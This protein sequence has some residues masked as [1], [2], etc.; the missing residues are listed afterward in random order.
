S[1]SALLQKHHFEPWAANW[2]LPELQAEESAGLGFGITILLGL[3]LL[4]ISL[5]R[6]RSSEP[7]AAR[8]TDL[9]Q[10]LV[11]LA[12][13][14]SLFYVMT[15]LN[16]S[17]AVRYLA[18]YYPLLCAGLLLSPRHAGLVGRTWWRCWAFFAFGL[19]GLVLVISPDRPL[20]PSAWFFQSYGS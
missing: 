11:C 9:I 14:V 1:L 13:W 16:L 2:H 12:P 3:S 4:A 8:S 18:A 7:R 17:S 20:W 19:A 6:G 5:G 10:R 15:K